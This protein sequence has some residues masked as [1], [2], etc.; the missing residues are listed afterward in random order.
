LIIKNKMASKDNS[1]LQR[2]RRRLG[3][4]VKKRKPIKVI[5]K[6]SR[7][8]GIIFEEKYGFLEHHTSKGPEDGFYISRYLIYMIFLKFK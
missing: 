4:I 8:P 2:K 7:G 3:W 5:F 6:D 1:R